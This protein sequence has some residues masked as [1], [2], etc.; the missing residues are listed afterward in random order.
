[1]HD[2]RAAVVISVAGAIAVAAVGDG[3]LH[4]DGNLEIHV[5]VVVRV[6]YGLRMLQHCMPE[7]FMPHTV[8]HRSKLHSH[9]NLE[10]GVRSGAGPNGLRS[11]VGGRAAP[12]RDEC[13]CCTSACP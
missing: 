11:A 9:A 10:A 6:L 5:C 4:S 3:K 2:V 13:C 8:S 1:M 12:G 7:S